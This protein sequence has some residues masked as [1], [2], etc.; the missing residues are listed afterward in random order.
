[1]LT[2]VMKI[3]F[4]KKAMDFILYILAVLI[5]IVI[6][7]YLIKLVLD[8]KNIL[9]SFPPSTQSLSASVESVLNLFVLIEFFRGAM[10]YFDFDRIKLSFIADAAMVF[11]LREVMIATFYHKLDFKMAIGYS[12]IMTAVAGLRTLTIIYTPDKE[13]RVRT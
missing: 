11:I 9:F 5:L 13:K 1:M 7:F 3:K 12:I 10:S 4:I 2:I 8:L 6:G